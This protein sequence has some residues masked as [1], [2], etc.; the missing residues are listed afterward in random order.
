HAPASEFPHLTGPVEGLPEES[1]GD[2][3]IYLPS[4]FRIRSNGGHVDTDPAVVVER[5]AHC[6]P[7]VWRHIPERDHD[8]RLNLAARS[9][10]EFGDVRN[11][12]LNNCPWHE[13]LQKRKNIL[14]KSLQGKH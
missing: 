7:T 3:V 9:L 1:K 11:A 2:L 8:V 6:V 13:I 12:A 4:G 5:P 14:L 10:R